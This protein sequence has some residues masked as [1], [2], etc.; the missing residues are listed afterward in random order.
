MKKYEL[1]KLKDLIYENYEKAEDRKINNPKEHRKLITAVA[2]RCGCK[3]RK[4]KD[5][6]DFITGTNLIKQKIK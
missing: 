2:M 1:D 3:S 4:W 6:N 5:V